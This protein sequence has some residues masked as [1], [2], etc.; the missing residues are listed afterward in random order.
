M[1]VT[2]KANI[3]L[4]DDQ[5]A[6]L[7]S[8][9]VILSELGENLIKAG[10]AREA[11]EHLLRHDI[12]VILVDV[13]MPDLDGFQLAEMIRSHPR[14]E[15]TAMIFI[16]AVMMSDVDRL[17][18]YEAGAVDYVPVPV[19][20]EVLRAKVRVFVEL[21]R[22]T[23]Q[24]EQLN[25]ELE[26]RVAERT[27]DLEHTAA[28]LQQSERRRSLALAAGGMGSWDWNADTNELM[29]DDAQHRI[30]GTD[31]ARFA[32]TAASA[33]A[34]FHPEDREAQIRAIRQAATTGQR[35][36]EEFRIIRP[37]GAIRWCFASAAP[38]GDANGRPRRLSGVTLDIT[39]RKDAEA[40]QMMLAREVDHRAKNAL[41][42]VQSVLRLT[43]APSVPEFVEAVE[44]RI[45]AIAWVHTL[46]SN[47]RWQGAELV[48]LVREEMAPYQ[49]GDMPRVVF[50][51]P[52]VML[53][54]ATAQSLA[55]S[56][57]ELATNAAKYGSLS[58]PTGSVRLTWHCRADVLTLT[59][60]ETGGPSA[61][62]PQSRGFG[63]RAITESVERQLCG[64][65]EMNWLPTG[66]VCTFSIP[67]SEVGKLVADDTVPVA[68][69]APEPAA[70]AHHL[71][72]GLRVLVV[73]DEAMVAMMMEQ[74]LLDLGMTVVGPVGTLP[75][76]L[77]LAKAGGIDC[78]ILDVNLQG[79]PIYPVADLLADTGVP[80]IFLTGYDKVTMDD[81]YHGVAVLQKPVRLSDLE[82]VLLT[83][84][85]PAASPPVR[86]FATGQVASLA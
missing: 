54:P 23:R 69:P 30:F 76:A 78:A 50:D 45:G 32:V 49:S 74:A 28:R 7:L 29:W 35:Y 11:L 79:T 6:K 63:I 47:S 46:L 75:Q 60:R 57:H 70:P 81:R 56:I 4:V 34:L 84:I 1:D 82:R 2:P 64:R 72:P 5:P 3:L 33:W 52:D 39:E 73:D 18:G 26:R 17:R 9:E 31:P 68:P 51:G 27:A 65:V 8:Y 61:T 71:P 36:G 66:L 85:G 44:G 62:S 10:S 43:R 22:K 83:L 40:R 80:F 53:L 14:F 48:R 41:A 20:P 77:A 67:M 25:A 12:A 58:V 21:H 37:D 59:W 13:C 38:T 16:S 42:V 55:L 15:K 24:L 86:V 19:V